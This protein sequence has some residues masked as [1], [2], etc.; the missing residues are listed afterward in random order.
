MDD[1]KKLSNNYFKLLKDRSKQ[2]RVYK[3]HQMTGLI[4]A[5]L[6]DDS[7]HKS[8]YMRLSKIYDNDELIRIA[9]NITER[10]N[11][12]NKGAY[13]MRVFKASDIHKIKEKNK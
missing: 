13:F 4:L 1:F 10:K 9:K 8:L 5:Q 2:S 3:P 7:S 11:I 12:E 6:L